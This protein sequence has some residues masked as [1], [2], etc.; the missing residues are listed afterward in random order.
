M[1]ILISAHFIINYEVLGKVFERLRL[2]SVFLSLFGPPFETRFLQ[3]TICGVEG[4]ILLTSALY[5]NV[6]GR[7]WIICYFIVE[8]LI[9]CGVQFLDLWD[10][11]S[12]AKIDCTYSFWLVEL[13]GKAFV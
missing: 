6:M 1:G 13:V 5:V 9:G 10:F 8:K 4:L 11:M 2:L 3:V 12:L 7:Q